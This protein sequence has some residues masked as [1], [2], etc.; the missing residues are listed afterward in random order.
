MLDRKEKT[1]V[2]NIFKTNKTALTLMWFQDTKTSKTAPK[3]NSSINS[4]DSI[5]IFIHTVL[6]GFGSA[7]SFAVCNQNIA[8]VAVEGHHVRLGW[9]YPAPLKRSFGEGM[10]FERIKAF[11]NE[12][13]HNGRGRGGRKGKTTGWEKLGGSVLEE[14]NRILQCQWVEGTVSK[15]GIAHWSRHTKDLAG[16]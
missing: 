11:L 6:S 15:W 14:A 5:W 3:L 7:T 8:G 16:Q 1:P 9:I 4:I 2:I 13:W 12:S 10:L